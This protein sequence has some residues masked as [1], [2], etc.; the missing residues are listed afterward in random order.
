MLTGTQ[1]TVIRQGRK[2]VAEVDFAANPGE[3]TVI[4]GRNGA[5]KSTLLRCLSGELK[6][7][8]GSVSYFG[9]KLSNWPAQELARCRAVVAQSSALSFPFRLRE[10]VELGRS[11]H[12]QKN[13]GALDWAMDQMDLQPLADRDYTTLSGGERQRTH[14]AR[15]LAQMFEAAE[16]GKGWLLLDEPTSSLDLAHQHQALEC[17]RTLAHRGLGVVAVLHDLNL[18]AR[19]ADVVYLLN[20]GECLARGKTSEVLEPALLSRAYGAP[21]SRVSGEWF[22]VAG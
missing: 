15:A 9:R 20:D 22:E 8:G 17:A 13:E 12:W 11:P 3:I 14:F 2:L 6:P 10:V 5:G 4:L 7:N 1:I 19:Y 18:C 16:N 21:I